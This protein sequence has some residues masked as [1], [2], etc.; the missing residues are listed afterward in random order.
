[1]AKIKKMEVNPSFADFMN[2]E[3]GRQYA[4]AHQVAAMC[5]F[6]KNAFYVL[7]RGVPHNPYPLYYY[8][9]ILNALLTFADDEAEHDDIMRR[10]GEAMSHSRTYTE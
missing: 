6:N 9:D 4:T 2:R 3:I 1:M 8:T 10:W 7:K 5:K